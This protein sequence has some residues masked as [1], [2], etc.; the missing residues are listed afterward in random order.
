MHF[1]TCSLV[2]VESRL[3]GTARRF[4]ESEF[5]L[6]RELTEVS[7]IIKPYPK[8]EERK[9]ECLK[10]LSNVQIAGVKY[11]P[12]NPDSMLISVDYSSA[13]PMQRYVLAELQIKIL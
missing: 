3:E 1:S 11:L 2:Q 6:I 7:A 5:E 4:K 12:S 13:S 10:A 9:K 8:G